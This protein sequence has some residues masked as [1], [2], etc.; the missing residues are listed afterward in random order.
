MTLQTCFRRS[1]RLPGK[2]TLTGVRQ[3]TWLAILVGLLGTHV[4][5]HERHDRSGSGSL[6][7]QA[8]ALQARHEFS[9]ALKLTADMLAAR[10][11]D[12]QAWLLRASLYL[13]RGEIDEAAGSC[14]ELRHSSPLVVVTCHA[15][16]ARAAGDAMPIR[17]KLDGLIDLSDAERIEPQVLAWSLSV[18][19]DL[20][21]AAGE[22]QRA[23]QYFRRSLDRF[24]NPQ[25]RASLIDVLIEEN[26]LTEARRVLDAGATSLTLHVQEL[27]IRKRQGDDIAR[28]A[29]RLVRRFRHWMEHGDYEHAREM[30]RFHLDVTGDVDLAH[31][32][33]TI[34]ASLQHEPEDR[35][36]VQ[37]AARAVATSAD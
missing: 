5:A 18:A 13:V 4:S 20:A 8:V 21:V 12:D 6:F 37:R 27:I 17:H 32:L 16:V 33:A 19:G 36:L 26:Q 23:A 29:A 35:L 9:G 34:N 25:V 24:D 15:N 11:D 28:D 10:P 14:R 2:R 3:I 7:E 30:A 1:R 22:S 31:A